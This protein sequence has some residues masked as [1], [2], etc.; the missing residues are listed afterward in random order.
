MK[1]VS[2]PP[3]KCELCGDVNDMTSHAD[4]SPEEG[5]LSICWNCGMLTIFQE[6]LTQRKLTPEELEEYQASP[7]WSQVAKAMN[8]ILDRGRLVRD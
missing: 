7:S 8:F 1:Q 3:H 2:V 4:K 6:D 5:N